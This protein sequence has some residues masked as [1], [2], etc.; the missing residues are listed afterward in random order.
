MKKIMTLLVVLL[1]VSFVAFA[2]AKSR[3]NI[4]SFMKEYETFVT[5]AEKAASTNS[6]SDLASLSAESVKFSEKA[7]AVQ[8][9]KDW[10]LK[11]SQKYLELTNRYSAAL[12]KISG[13]ANTITDT[14]NAA[15]SDLLK[16]YGY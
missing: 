12:S 6:L 2:D 8:D 1:G 7:Q 3:K 13:T 10:T 14:T 5:K 9:A 4:D 11:D 16:S 15:A